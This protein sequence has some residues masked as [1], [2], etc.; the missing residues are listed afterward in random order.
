MFENSSVSGR[1]HVCYNMNI[2]GLTDCWPAPPLI[3]DTAFESPSMFCDEEDED[4]D[5]DDDVWM[6][7]M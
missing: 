2:T 1:G 5:D 7:L 6:E 3:A 4:D